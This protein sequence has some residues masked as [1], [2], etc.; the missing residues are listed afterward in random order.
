MTQKQAAPSEGLNFSDFEVQML[1]LERNAC[2][3]KT[4]ML[5]ALLNRIGEAKGFQDS[6]EKTS[7]VPRDTVQELAFSVLKW[8]PQ[9]GAKIGSYETAAKA[10]NDLV[11]WG[12][13]YDILSEAKATIKE[14]YLGQG[15]QFSYWLFGQ[16][17]IYR[18][19]HKQ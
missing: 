19:K 10:S 2:Q 5:D 8:D 17:K 9:N 15:Y 12:T 11:K 16:D 1:I 18:Q 14:R 6:G 7:K 13:A 3:A 4:E